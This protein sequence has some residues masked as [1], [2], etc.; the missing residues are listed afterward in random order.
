MKRVVVIPKF[1]AK[2]HRKIQ[3]NP[4]KTIRGMARE[5]KVGET[6]IRSAVKELGMKS[7]AKM[8]TTFCQ[9]G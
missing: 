6:S 4:S 8:T 3:L 2:I 5:L 7:R 9:Y 1:K